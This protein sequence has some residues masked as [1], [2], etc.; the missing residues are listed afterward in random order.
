MRPRQVSKDR[1]AKKPA[2][3]PGVSG[4][5]LEAMER[6]AR[7]LHGTGVP[8]RQL[9]RAFSMVCRNLAPAPRARKNKEMID[10]PH[11]LTLWF[12]D[13]AFLNNRGL[14]RALPLR[15]EGPSL[16]TLVSRV[17]PT[18]PTAAIASYL[19][20][21]GAIIRVGSRY[22][23]ARHAVSLR[24]TYGPERARAQRPLLGMLRTLEHNMKPKAEVGSWFE[25]MAENPR[26]PV[27][28]LAKL[29]AKVA[30]YGMNLLRSLD[31]EMHKE[32]MTCR[33]GDPTVRL[34]IGIYWFEDAGD[35]Q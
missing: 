7:V 31:I 14:P 3:M 29:D 10:A 12:R 20:K 4:T 17:N 32:E 34:G 26:V 27:R 11:L 5:A 13:R 35:V 28:S 18:L 8:P 9:S 22:A 33:S 25:W 24:G 30:R 1:R 6:F 2:A 16:E 15:G 23:P 19:M 21:A